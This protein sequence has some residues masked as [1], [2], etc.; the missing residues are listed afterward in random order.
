MTQC[1]TSYEAESWF[2]NRAGS[3]DCNH[4]D[5]ETLDEAFAF[6]SR[7]R[8]SSYGQTVFTRDESGKRIPIW[9]DAEVPRVTQGELCTI[10]GAMRRFGFDDAHVAVNPLNGECA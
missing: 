9:D 6:L 3:K 8:N 4:K 10:V 7:H 2:M 1:A 5:C